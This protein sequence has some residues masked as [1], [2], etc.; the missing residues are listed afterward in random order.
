MV[1][2]AYVVGNYPPKERKEREDAALAHASAD[3][4]VGIISVKAD[5]YIH[6]MSP[7]EIQLAAPAFIEAFREAE[8]AGYDAVVPLGVLDLGVDGGRSAVDIPVIAPLEAILH[9]ASLLGDRFGLIVYDETFIPWTR[10]MVRNYGMENKIAGW[11]AT[12]ISLPDMTANHDAVITNFVAAARSLIERDGAEVILPLGISQC[13]IHIKPDWLMDQLSVPVVEGIG[14][15]IRFAAM[16]AGLGLRHSRKRWP[17][18]QNLS[19]S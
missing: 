11:R 18:S 14:A 17:K 16:L 12:E 5:P 8:R 19:P 2:V 13:P 15:P 6:G 3:V 9:V 1:K 10:A 4:E 7:T